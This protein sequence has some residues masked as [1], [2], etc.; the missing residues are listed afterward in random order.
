MSDAPQI[1]GPTGAA[2]APPPQ[3]TPRELL[4]KLNDLPDSLTFFLRTTE[5]DST[6]LHGSLTLADVSAKLEEY[7]VL[8]KEVE[9]A[10]ADEGESGDRMKSVGTREVTLSV[11]GRGKEVYVL[12]I[13]VERLT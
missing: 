2:P 3:P 9:V 8:P 11:K 5:A 4:Q 13:I 10:W 1:A 6:A 12:D 7:S